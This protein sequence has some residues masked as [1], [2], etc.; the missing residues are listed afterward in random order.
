[1]KIGDKV[2]YIF[3]KKKY[4]PDVEFNLDEY[5]DVGHD[6]ILIYGQ[7]Y[8]IDYIFGSSIREYIVLK[9]FKNLNFQMKYFINIREYRKQK[10]KRIN[11]SR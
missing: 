7:I 8:T 9:E 5:Y 10:L 11:E 3:K 1:M 2:V 4:D 6:D